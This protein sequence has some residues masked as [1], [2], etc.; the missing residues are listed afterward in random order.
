VRDFNKFSSFYLSNE[1]KIILLV[2]ICVAIAII[3]A[4]AVNTHM[5]LSALEP[6]GHGDESAEEVI[7]E[8]IT[9]KP[10]HSETDTEED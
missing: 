6:E 3:I 8:I 4:L 9:G 2:I 1:K 5:K 10:S 7:N